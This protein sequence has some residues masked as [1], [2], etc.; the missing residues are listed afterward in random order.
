MAGMRELLPF[1]SVLLALIAGGSIAYVA[2]DLTS[3]RSLGPR[4]G[5]KDDDEEPDD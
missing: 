4:D 1:L 3:E 2:W 5:R